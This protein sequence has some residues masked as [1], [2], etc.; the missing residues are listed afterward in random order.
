MRGRIIGLILFV[1]GLSYSVPVLAQDGSANVA[2]KDDQQVK[3]KLSIYYEYYKSKNYKDSYEAWEYVYQNCPSAHKNIYIHGPKLIKYKYKNAATPEEKQQYLAL[4]MEVY[5]ARL[6]NFPGK[7]GYVL[8]LKGSDMVNY[9]YGTSQEAYDIL[10]KAYQIDGDKLSAS[11]LYS[12]FTVST[13]LFNEKVFTDEQVFEVYDDVVVAIDINKEKETN[14]IAKYEQKAEDGATLSKS[15]AKK[16]KSAKNHLG[17]YETV[18]ANVEKIIGKIATCDRLDILYGSKFEERK[19]DI[20][21]V[22]GGVKMM[23]RK[24]CFDSKIFF[25]LIDS[26]S[27]LAPDASSSRVAGLLSLS[28]KEYSNALKYYNE[29]IELG[30]DANKKADDYYKAAQSLFKLGR[31]SEARSYAYKAIENR[32]GWGDPYILIGDMYASSANSCG[33]N[34]FEKK[35]VYWA[36]VAKYS[37]ARNVDPKVSKKASTKIGQWG[38]QAPDKTMIFQFGYIGKPK[39]KIGCWINETVSVPQT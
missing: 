22:N 14:I 6:V 4:L 38:A 26:K 13:R 16:L 17:A 9:K 1:V 33:S 27:K 7:E 2:C 28:N 23:T 5:D 34:V 35:A 19:N 37:Q 3:E 21:W 29:A 12:Y 8:G 32:K 39:Y 18:E 25:S 31:K 36:A 15:E 20:D 10:N 11:T 24:K 30:D